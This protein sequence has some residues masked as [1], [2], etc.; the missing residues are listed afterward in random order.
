[1]PG[2]LIHQHDSG[3]QYTA[4]TFTEHLALE[5]LAPS[6]G[7]VADAYDA[8]TSLIGLFKNECLRSRPS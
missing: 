1:V 5:G 2:E 6:I 4:L 8:L 7:S 3:S